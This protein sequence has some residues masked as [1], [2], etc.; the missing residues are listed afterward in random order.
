MT[1]GTEIV[2]IKMKLEDY[3]K[4]VIKDSKD[5]CT[6][7]IEFDLILDDNC[8]VNSDGKQEVHFKIIQIK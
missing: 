4:E 3:I 1:T 7:T 5:Q 8:E 2:I 6:A